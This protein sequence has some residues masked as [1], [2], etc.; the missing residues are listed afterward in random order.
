MKIK[1]NSDI[2]EIIG[3]EGSKIKN[4]FDPDSTD[5]EIRFSMAHFMIQK[6]KR[7]LLHRMKSSEVYY[8]LEG[9]GILKINGK[10]FTVKKDDSV[11]VPPMSEQS[12][13][14]IGGKDL[15]FLCIVDPAWNQENEIVLE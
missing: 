5:N 10:S 11:F 6:G 8:I 14:N 15:R 3:H 1:R 13:E 7:T 9:V 4:Y 12:I 2:P